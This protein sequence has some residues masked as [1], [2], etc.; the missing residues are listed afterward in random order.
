[1]ATLTQAEHTTSHL[2]KSYNTLL[3]SFSAQAFK[4]KISLLVKS[5]PKAW[6]PEAQLFRAMIMCQYMS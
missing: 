2:A 6:S 1:M 3:V 4:S 5:Q